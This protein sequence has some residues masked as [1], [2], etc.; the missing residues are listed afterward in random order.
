MSNQENLVLL[1]G[2]AMHSRIWGDFSEQLALHYRVTLVGLKSFENLDVISNEIVAQLDN[3]PFYLLGWS[4]GGAL[5]LNIAEKY[6]NQ[7]QCVIL[8]SANPCFVETENWHGMPIETFNAFSNQLENNPSQTLQR[9]LS[10]QCQGVPK[11]LKELKF[12]FLLKD[13]P[14]L[15]DLQSSLMLLKTCDLR[16]TIS[17]LT[18]PL[19]AI[20]S[21]ND[22]LIPV[23]IGEKM[24]LLQPN[25]QLTIL[26]NAGHIPFI[27]QPENC[28][29]VINT[30]LANSR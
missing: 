19:L 12:R 14:E 6:S 20:L 21:D 15:H 16:T 27:T 18:C 28:L 9:F 30:F 17:K 4:L 8:L 5:A 7:V 3:E 24:Q 1:H 11:F 22:S 25:L 13:A 26:K 29:N 2:W 23:E 10:L